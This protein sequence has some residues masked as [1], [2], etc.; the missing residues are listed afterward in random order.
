MMHDRAGK[1]SGGVL[2]LATPRRG[3][4]PFGEGAERSPPAGPHE[5]RPPGAVDELGVEPCLAHQLVWHR[6]D[7]HHRADLGAQP[8]KVA[9]RDLDVLGRDDL[10]CDVE[11]APRP[12]PPSAGVLTRDLG[13]T[14]T[15]QDVTKALIGALN[16]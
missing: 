8:A 1:T 12:V 9:A 3:P 10:V 5:L 2:Q 16:T 7:H 13:G 6:V 4:E 15:T 11:D 14:A